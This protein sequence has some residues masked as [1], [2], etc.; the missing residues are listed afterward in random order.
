M[1]MYWLSVG[2]IVLFSALSVVIY[3]LLLK[4]SESIAGQ[5]FLKL[6]VI[7]VCAL[8]PIWGINIFYQRYLLPTRLISYS[9]TK[10]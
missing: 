3:N 5:F 7:W 10:L 4:R 8:F 9:V 2:G 6:A 1:K